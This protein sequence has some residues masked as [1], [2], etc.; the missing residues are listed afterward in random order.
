MREPKRFLKKTFS[1]YTISMKHMLTYISKTSKKQILLAIL[2]T[3]C[4]ITLASFN[5]TL[6]ILANKCFTPN[7][8][9]SP[10]I[11]PKEL[12]TSPTHTNTHNLLH[13]TYNVPTK[14][15]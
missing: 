6:L 3:L 15:D 10:L 1:Y 2:I 7:P 14:L 13:N 5:N 11:V 12:A 4:N 8:K 9:P